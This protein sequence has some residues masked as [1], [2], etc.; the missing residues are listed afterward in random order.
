MSMPLSNDTCIPGFE[1]SQL[2]KRFNLNN[3]KVIDPTIS[4]KK[5][6]DD[7]DQELD[8]YEISMRFLQ[9]LVFCGLAENQTSIQEGEVIVGMPSP[10]NRMRVI[11]KCFSLKPYTSFLLIPASIKASRTFAHIVSLYSS[12][13]YAIV[14]PCRRIIFGNAKRFYCDTEWLVINPGEFIPGEQKI[15]LLP[16]METKR[17]AEK[18]KDDTEVKIRKTLKNL[19][20]VI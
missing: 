15:I 13:I 4:S 9:E 7:Y 1:I 10:E 18:R 11:E 6:G 14:I 5:K 16:F 3:Y 19:E 17:K 20:D 12:V 2:Y 8:E